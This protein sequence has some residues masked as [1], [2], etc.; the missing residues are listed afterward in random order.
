MTEIELMESKILIYAKDLSQ[1]DLAWVTKQDLLYI[2]K[3]LLFCN[4]KETCSDYHKIKNLL[5]K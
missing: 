2:N 5:N 3:L 4:Q 1:K